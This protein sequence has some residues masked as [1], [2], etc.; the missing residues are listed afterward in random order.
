MTRTETKIFWGTISN[1]ICLVW[2]KPFDSQY[3]GCSGTDMDYRTPSV[4][5]YDETVEKVSKLSDQIT[6]DHFA[7]LNETIGLR[8]AGHRNGVTLLGGPSRS[9]DF[10]NMF[11]FDTETGLF[12][13]SYLEDFND[14]RKFTTDLKYDMYVGL[15]K[16]D[17]SGMIL[18]YTGDKEE[19]IK[20]D[21]IA[22]VEQNPAENSFYYDRLLV[23][24]WPVG[25][26]LT[27]AES[28]KPAYLMVSPIAADSLP[29]IG[30]IHRE[31]SLSQ[32]PPGV[33]S[34]S[35][36]EDTKQLPWH[37]IW[38]MSEYEKD[39]VIATI[40]G[41]S[42]SVQIGDWLYWGTVQFP[43]SGLNAWIQA[44]GRPKDKKTF[45][46]YDVGAHRAM[47]MFR[48][49]DLLHGNR[50]VEL[51]Y[52]NR[53]LPVFNN[54]SSE[55][56][57]WTLEVNGM[58]Q[59]P[60]LGRGG[61]GNPQNLYL[62]SMTVI[63]GDTLLIGTYDVYANTNAVVTPSAYGYR[64]SIMGADLYIMKTGTATGSSKSGPA[65]EVSSMDDRIS[66]AE[67]I[68]LSGLTDELNYGVRNILS[69]PYNKSNSEVIIGTASGWN[70]EA[71]SGFEVI[72][73]YLP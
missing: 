46:S 55:Q 64:P 58:E 15:S 40:L 59:T 16:P 3:V 21:V 29:S 47:A 7:R 72:K 41:V 70:V 51:L 54:D 22:V 45:V 28:V 42:V 36:L 8:A 9:L 20:F 26:D 57:C 68:S 6:G 32:S 60:K 44:Y 33:L 19:P 24:T 67:Y 71:G 53:V 35:G 39:P 38:N 37:S 34:A 69:D 56:N 50:I 48:G 31:S 66:A 12:L 65:D 4:Y 62:W 2:Q 10:V 61:F 14:I 49:R 30:K 5:M 18:R 13:D 43:N 73:L 11:A 17:D 1:M 27:D 25:G 23:G 52:G 63:K